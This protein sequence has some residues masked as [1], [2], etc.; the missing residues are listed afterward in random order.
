V[1]GWHAGRGT[2]YKSRITLMKLI[3]RIKTKTNGSRRWF[4]FLSA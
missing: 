3:T 2:A 1:L 4:L